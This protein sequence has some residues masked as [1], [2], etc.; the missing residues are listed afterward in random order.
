M[1]D[2]YAIWNAA[3]IARGET[4]QDGLLR[5]AN[6]L[7]DDFAAPLTDGQIERLRE[8]TFSTNN[9]FCP[10]DQKSMLKAVRAAERAHGIG[11]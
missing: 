11:T 7:P 8:A 2:I 1:A 3:Q 10:V 9:P 6:L 5:V 4:M